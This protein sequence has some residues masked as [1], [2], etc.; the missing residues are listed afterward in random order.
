MST[1][2]PNH[3][4]I[5]S[6]DVEGTAVYDFQDNKIGQVDHLMINKITGHVHYAVLS[7]GGFLSFAHNHY[8][9]PW[10]KL[11]FDTSLDGFRVDIGEAQLRDAP[12]FSDDSWSNR[13]WERNVHT[14][15][16]IPPYWLS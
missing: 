8:P 5:S 2:H 13:T 7:F 3:L 9:I 12:E 6:D 16:E 15:Y 11:K 4:F 1:A 14:H 10:Q